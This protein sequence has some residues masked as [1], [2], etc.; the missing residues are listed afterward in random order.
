MTPSP[1]ED[2]HHRKAW[3]DL[4]A[5]DDA[6]LSP[7]ERRGRYPREGERKRAKPPLPSSPDPQ[8][9]RP[10][11]VDPAT[12]G[13]AGEVPESDWE[14][15]EGVGPG[16]RDATRREETGKPSPEEPPEEDASGERPG[17]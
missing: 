3:V 12:Q 15:Q 4:M 6:D 5:Q 7:L 11:K 14:G 9:P 1:V 8:V 16:P 2:R 10:E 13:P 17:S